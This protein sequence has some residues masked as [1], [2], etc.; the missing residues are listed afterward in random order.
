MDA[1]PILDQRQRPMG[2]LR[3]SITDRCNLRCGYCMPGEN[4]TWMPNA[5]LLSFEELTRVANVFA[6]L[7]VR[8]VRLTGGEPLLRKD[9]WK[10][11]G[12]LKALGRFDEVALTTNGL[13][14]V[15]HASA[16]RAAGLDRLTV[17][18]DS[19]RRDR[20]QAM[21]GRDSLDR[22][23]AGLDAAAAAGF[24]G[25]KLDV[26]AMQGFNDDELVDFLVFGRARGLEVRFIE[27][28]DVLGATEWSADKVVS[29]RTM[30]ARVATAVGGKAVP[31]GERGSAPAAR[32]Q[33][34]KSA[35][36]RLDDAAWKRLEVVTRGGLSG[37]ATR[38]A[39]P[40]TRTV[41]LGGAVFGII[42]STTEPFCADCD[43]SR[44]TAD[45]RWY[46]CLYS[47]DG[48][49]LRAPLRAG[50]SDGEL[51]ELLGGVWA[52][53]ADHGAEERAA[54]AERGAAAGREEL[55]RDPHLEMH[56]RGG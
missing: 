51:V 43:R 37:P 52:R 22:V 1:L 24:R 34:P 49:D 3:L 31:F 54:E 7:G 29:A 17:S 41:E 11:V 9:A 53:R 16:L 42:A 20:V 38:I 30:L 47:R 2:S 5:D 10:L 21:S 48:L 19:L 35:R 39:Q 45:G 32:F 18:L 26:V 55:V 6:E 15:E 27:Y 50:A 14:L 12:M 46:G 44:V 25:T 33:L 40:A 4:Y 23:L 8:K 36:V 13:G 56:K 28:M